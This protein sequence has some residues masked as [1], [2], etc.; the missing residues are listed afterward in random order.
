M[1]DPRDAIVDRFMDRFVAHRRRNEALFWVAYLA[2][3]NTLGAL[4][5]VSDHARSG[6]DLQSWEAFTWEY[7]SGLALVVL[8][9]LV[10]L[11]NRRFPLL[12]ETLGKA[13]AMHLMVS[14]VFSL[15]HV[16]LMV[17]LREVVY[18]L[19]DSSYDFGN[20]AVELV[21]EYRK[22]LFTYIQIL[23]IFYLYGYLT[24]RHAGEARLLSRRD[25]PAAAPDETAC[26]ERFL[27]RKR[28]R[29]FVIRVDEI[30]WAEAAGNYVNLHVASSVYPLRETMQRLAGQLPDQFA[31][32]HRSAIV[33]LER[34]A[35][36][37]P[38][39][40]GDYQIEMRTG[41]LVNFSRRYRD[42]VKSMLNDSV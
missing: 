10:A 25:E 5:V 39:G 3:S 8:I 21:Y 34:V 28:G 20:W 17:G 38:L 1:A 2:L 32:V 14:V 27:V 33:N 22:D 7:T 6:N 16:L 15:A 23:V 40:T 19:M 37:R 13:L 36:I 42:T 4:T 26:P 11:I 29:E 18:A 41:A 30:D 24:R 12:P 35:E 9:P 31:R